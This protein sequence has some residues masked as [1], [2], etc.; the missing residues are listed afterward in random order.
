MPLSP[1]A[2]RAAVLIAPADLALMMVVV[3]VWGMNFA[4]IK[5]GVVGIPPLL[6]GAMRFM[7][8]AFPALLFFKAPKVPLRWYVLYGMT[9]SVGQFAFLF[10]AIHVEKQNLA[11]LDAL[12]VWAEKNG[13]PGAKFT[14]LF[15]SF[16]VVGKAR[17]AAQLQEQFKVEGVPA[18]G[19][20]GRFY[21]DG[22]L[23]GTMDRALQVTDHLLAE[24]R[25]GH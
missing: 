18:L 2:P 17:R 25:K 22:S 3:L 15:N 6:L 13:I 7:L 23:T 8:A 4:V 16:S 19:I 20:G 12:V 21:V 9:I 14:E 11:K 10:S 5:V 1:N 24:I